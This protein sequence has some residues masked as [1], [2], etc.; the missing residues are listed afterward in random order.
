MPISGF[1]SELMT[2]LSTLGL[3]FH[4]SASSPRNSSVNMFASSISGWSSWSS[5]K[6]ISAFLFPWRSCKCL[7]NS[8]AFKR[9]LLPS[10]VIS[11]T[12]FETVSCIWVTL[13]VC[14]VKSWNTWVWPMRRRS[15]S[16]ICAVCNTSSLFTYT[17]ETPVLNNEPRLYLAVN[18]PLPDIRGCMSSTISS[19][20]DASLEMSSVEMRPPLRNM[21][22]ASGGGSSKPCDCVPIVIL[23]NI[24]PATSTRTVDPSRFTRVHISGLMP[25]PSICTSQELS[26]PTA[27]SLSSSSVYVS[28]PE[29]NGSSQ[30]LT[31]YG[32]ASFR[33]HTASPLLHA[34]AMS[35]IVRPN[36]SNA[37]A[38]SLSKAIDCACCSSQ[39]SVKFLCKSLVVASCSSRDFC[40]LPTRPASNCCRNASISLRKWLMV[41]P[42]FSSFCT[43][44]VRIFFTEEAKRIVDS[45]IV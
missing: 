41:S 1:K 43:A 20:P 34:E 8:V 38:R 44:F 12:I 26:L 35:F 2:L 23:V 30:T 29:S 15:P 33:T 36:C 3:K 42:A 7:A 11:E 18:R 4:S 10:C 27:I 37:P 24:S 17:M 22:F 16:C 13:R 40:S 9:S 45:V 32:S 28:T 25:K 21:T 19:L 6:T 31:R 14:G 5:L 39:V